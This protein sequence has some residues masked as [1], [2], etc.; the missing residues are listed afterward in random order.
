MLAGLI[1]GL[2]SRTKS[3]NEVS[4]HLQKVKWVLTHRPANPYTPTRQFK[5]KILKWKKCPDELGKKD[6]NGN[7]KNP[8][9]I[10]AQPV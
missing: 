7:R 5:K 9:K 3:K 2:K 1:L 10:L 4:V 6:F 8:T